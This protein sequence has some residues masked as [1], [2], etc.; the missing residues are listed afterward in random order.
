MNQRT[1]VVTGGN[2]GIGF[3][4]CRQL[5]QQGIRVVLTARD[6]QKGRKAAEKLQATGAD[7]RFHPL[8]ITDQAQ[9]KAL[10][11]HVCSDLGHLDILINNAGVYLDQHQPAL[12][13]SPD[14]ILQAVQTD[15][16][17]TLALCQAVIPL[18]REQQYGRIV[19]LSSRTSKL[20]Q[21]NNVGLT[22]KIAKA[23]INAITVVLSQEVAEENILI[24]A[25]NPGW[26]KTD[27]G[28]Q[29]AI[30]SP[31]EGANGPVWLATLPD[32]GPTGCFFDGCVQKPW[33]T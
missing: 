14:L 18:M 27:M 16:C 22:Y 10:V 32:H 23:A 28:G 4:I 7:V 8:D 30:L 13:I 19:N 25:V 3:E 2:R 9:I 31:T 24:N 5:A 33:S 1:A 17:G 20:D 15:V 12:S 29:D 26:I 6:V 21:M 11:N